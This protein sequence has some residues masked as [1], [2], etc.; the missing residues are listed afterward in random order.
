M[1]KRQRKDKDFMK[2]KRL[3][4]K[5][6]S[7]FACALSQSVDGDILATPKDRAFVRLSLDPICINK[8]NPFLFYQIFKKE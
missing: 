4:K 3:G 6:F 1:M 7:I 2:K 8:S 5:F